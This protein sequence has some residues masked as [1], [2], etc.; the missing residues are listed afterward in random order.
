MY[1]ISMKSFR[2][3][4]LKNGSCFL[5][6]ILPIIYF[7]NSVFFYSYLTSKLFFFYGIVEI[8]F[9]SWIYTIITDRSYSLSRKTWLYFIPLGVYLIWLTITGILG[10]NPA[11]SFWSSFGRG[12]GLLTLY[13]CLALALII[14]SLV[15]KWGMDF[16]YK[17]MRWFLNGSFILAVSLWFGNEGFNVFPFLR[18]SAGGG[19]MGNSSL[20]AT[21]L[22][23]ALAFGSFILFSKNIT[24]KVKWWT[25]ILI[26][27]ILFSPLFINI[28][29]LFNGH[30]L[31]GSARGATIGIFVGVVVAGIAYLFFSQKKIVQGL[32]IILVIIGSL[33]F[34]IEW[35][36]LVNPNTNL[37]KSFVNVASDTRFI[38]WDSAQKAI[39]K[40]PWLGYGPENFMIAFQDNFNP[41]IITTNDPKN[42]HGDETWTD[43]AHNVYYDMGISGGY[44]AIAFYTLFILSIMYG[45]FKLRNSEKVNHIQIAIL[46][47][48]IAGYVFQNLFVF[49]S[50][51]SLVALFVLSGIIFVFQDNLIGQK[52]PTRPMNLNVKNTIAMVLFITFFIALIFFTYRPMKKDITYNRIIKM[53]INERQDH[54]PDLLKGVSMGN[55][56]DTSQIADVISKYY[57]FNLINVKN[58]KNMLP[59]AEND[60][61]GLSK[62]LEVVTKTNKTDQRLYLS[63]VTS[64]IT[65]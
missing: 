49:D 23:F 20:T 22:L 2:E 29:G 63:L 56:F 64:Y 48:L 39:N 8:L 54:Y 41:K 60:L 58:D 28:L 51:H 46:G 33:S 65:I 13:H 37:H 47:G 18:D 19:L 55:Q 26:V 11:L 24:K 15:K 42:K 25:G 5:I 4:L 53:P 57:S 30:G 44:P 10:V 17:F 43:R 36:K 40:H 59:Y 27:V 52:Q 61:M 6:F 50:L 14:A 38:F 16:V 31:F 34:V 9:T 21:Y 3:K 7:G 12:T 32:A 1:N 62:Y 35:A 45:L